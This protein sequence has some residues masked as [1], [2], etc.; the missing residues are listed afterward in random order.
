MSNNDALKNFLAERQMTVAALARAVNMTT[1]P[2][3][4]MVNG[5]QRVSNNLRWRFLEAFGADE[6]QRV[7]GPTPP[8]P[9]TKS[10]LDPC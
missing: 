5:R 9:C 4:R 1:P 2:V 6:A 7:F 8:Y 10:P 3:W